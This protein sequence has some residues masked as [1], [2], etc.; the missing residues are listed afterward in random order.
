L[1]CQGPQCFEGFGDV[2]VDA[3]PGFGDDCAGGGQD[4][5]RGCTLDQFEADFFL[6]F[7]DLLGDRR[8]GDHEDVCG[9]YDAAFACHREQKR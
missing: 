5:P 3:F 9:G 2:C 1:A 6:E 8:G 7:L 4:C